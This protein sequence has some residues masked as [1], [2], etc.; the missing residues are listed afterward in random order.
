MFAPPLHAK[1]GLPTALLGSDLLEVKDGVG[2]QLAGPV[3]GD[4]APPVRSHEVRTQLFQPHFLLWRI[5][6]REKVQ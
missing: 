5:H 2:H 4:Q 1:H 6:L 3:E